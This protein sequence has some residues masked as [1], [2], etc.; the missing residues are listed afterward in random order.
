MVL[1]DGAL[2]ICW[3]NLLKGAAKGRGGA[4]RRVGG[5]EESCQQNSSPIH[6]QPGLLLAPGARGSEEERERRV[7]SRSAV[8]P[9]DPRWDTAAAA[10]RVNKC[11]RRFASN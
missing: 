7:M 11:G 9:R 1:S 5:T 6:A 4:A 10:A 8:A 3:S 2:P